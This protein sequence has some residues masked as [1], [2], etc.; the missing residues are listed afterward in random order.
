MPT[1]CPGWLIAEESLGVTGAG[2]LAI[3]TS[4]EDYT[5][6][7]GKKCAIKAKIAS[8]A[9]A[10]RV[11]VADGIFCDYEN[12]VHIEDVARCEGMRMHG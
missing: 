8:A 9:H 10:K 3:I 6:A 2:D 1:R 7:N 4:S 5:F 11:L 12:V